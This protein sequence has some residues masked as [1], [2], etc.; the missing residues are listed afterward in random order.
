MPTDA[1]APQPAAPTDAPPA[2]ASH[3]DAPRDPSRDVR[4]RRDTRVGLA[5]AA[6]ILAG[7][8]T[9]AWATLVH[10]R[11]DALG[12]AT[13]LAALPVIALQSWLGAGLFIVAHDAMHGT[14]APTRPRLADA[15]GRV[16][17]ALYAGFS[18]DRLR[19]AHHDHHRHPGTALD[20]DF[21]A[22][23]PTRFWP[24]YLHFVR[25]YFGLAQLAA[26]A[27]FF[28]IAV[29]LGVPIPN[30]VAFWA[31]PAILSSLQLFRW[32]T[33][34]PHRHE[35]APFADAH[36]ARS[37]RRG[38]VAT[39]ATCFHFGLHHEHHLRPDVPWWRLPAVR[40]ARVRAGEAR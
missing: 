12:T 17:L 36:R 35:A 37:D 10:W 6:A 13:P 11:W 23:H 3:G 18:Y 30:L 26:L 22:A 24:W 29:A 40:A 19:P 32:G 34:L 38:A 14:L 20:P 4:R 25:R 1:A 15:L 31:L 33:Y 21:D 8:A 7:W 28:W 2:D 16:A 9:L 5:L 27:A 39:L